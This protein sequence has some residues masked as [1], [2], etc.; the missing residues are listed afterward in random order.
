[1]YS[2][3]S[4]VNNT[5]CKDIDH[6]IHM[7]ISSGAKLINSNWLRYNSIM[8]LVIIAHLTTRMNQ[9]NILRVKNKSFCFLFQNR[10]RLLNFAVPVCPFFW[11]FSSGEDNWIN[12]LSSSSRT[13][14]SF[15]KAILFGIYCNS[16]RCNRT[17][18]LHVSHTLCVTYYL[19]SSGYLWHDI[20]L[21]FIIWLSVG[22]C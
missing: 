4:I 1:M 19:F 17:R 13:Y 2:I 14:S 12:T 6:S 18:H 11:F 9:C 10:F 7:S 15:H 21:L 20:S 22:W 8:L 16:R 5:A 3:L